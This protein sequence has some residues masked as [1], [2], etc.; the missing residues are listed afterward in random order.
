MVALSKGIRLIKDS[1]RV[2]FFGFLAS[3]EL[4]EEGEN[5]NVGNYGRPSCAALH[6]GI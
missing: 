3:K 1:Y 2:G 5:A 4:L 6:Q